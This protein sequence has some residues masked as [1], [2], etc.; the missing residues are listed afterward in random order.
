M[1][2]SVVVAAALVLCALGG[3]VSAQ[4]APGHSVDG[5]ALADEPTGA[6]WLAF[7]RTYKRA[8]LQPALPD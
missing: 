7:G 4:Q 3:Q 1:Q 6:H 8:A 2:R 5:A